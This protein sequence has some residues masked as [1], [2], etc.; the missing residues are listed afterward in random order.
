MDATAHLHVRL[1]F[2]LNSPRDFKCFNVQLVVSLQISTAEKCY[3][4]K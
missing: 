3:D 2:N 4:V 1:D